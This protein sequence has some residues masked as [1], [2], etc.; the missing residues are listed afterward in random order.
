MAA[1]ATVF[2]LPPKLLLP[3]AG[4]TR[5]TPTFAPTRWRIVLQFQKN[6]KICYVVVNLL[7]INAM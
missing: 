5:V 6:S 3:P 1:G 4:A 7:L 2:S